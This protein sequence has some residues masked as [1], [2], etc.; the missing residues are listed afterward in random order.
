MLM[1]GA[2]GWW[3][4]PTDPRQRSSIPAGM[5]GAQLIQQQMALSPP[6]QRLA[7]QENAAGL[8]G[9][10]M[11]QAL[12]A[13]RPQLR[14]PDPNASPLGS[15]LF[16]RQQTVPSQSPFG[17]PMAA[18]I[19]PMDSPGMSQ[20]IGSMFN[21]F[22]GSDSPFGLGSLFSSSSRLGGGSSLFGLGP[23]RSRVSLYGY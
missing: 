9:V 16:P 1:F 17:G 18:M 2:D 3:N 6:G 15:S 23:I 11:E 7:G 12:A 20:G 5:Q 8:P 13:S 19:Y 4:D 21:R 22:S 10:T 14:A